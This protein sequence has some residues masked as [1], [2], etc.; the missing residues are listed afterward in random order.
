MRNFTIIIVFLLAAY[1]SNAQVNKSNLRESV[2]DSLS[3]SL[4]IQGKHQQL[5]SLVHEAL[6]YD[7]D[8]YY[9]R[10]R[11]GVSY[12][13]KKQYLLALAH[14]YKALEF[15]PA[16]FTTKEYIFYC[17]LYLG[18]IEKAKEIVQKMPITYQSYYLSFVKYSNNINIESGY[19]NTNFSSNQDTSKFLA[20]GV[21]AE[22]DRTKSLQYYQLGGDFNLTKKVK[23]Y[24][25]VSLVNNLKSQHIYS[26][27][28]YYYYDYNNSIF[29]KQIKVKDTSLEY[30]LYQYQTYLGATINLPN[31]FTLLAGFQDMY[32]KQ[33]K[34]SAISDSSKSTLLDTLVYNYRYSLQGITQNNFAT[35]LTLMKSYKNW[36][37]QMSVG[38]ANI[39]K[40]S[41]FQAGGQFI[42]FPLGNYN[43]SLTAGYY[44]SKDTL[45]R[46]I[47]LFK[48]AGKIT[49]RLWFESYHY[50]GNLKN[51][52]ESNSYV[53]YNVSDAIKS[54]S[55]VSLTYYYS[56]RLSLGVRYDLMV[57]EANYDSYVKLNN[58][59]SK[60]VQ[61]DKYNMNSFIINL[62][63][64]Y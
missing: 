18:N 11:A 14:F 34:L 15:Y 16:D 54:K 60:I 51:F 17:H 56:Q 1:N 24:A 13:N 53:I 7:I 31:Q 36:Q 47:G 43:L 61:T 6:K 12:F 44:F 57:R 26:K 2:V 52:Q 48:I 62:I 59:T 10:L 30:N 46:N 8:F 37:G 55:G 49:E 64:K 38:F 45:T 42:Y 19:Q 63:W 50:Q 3:Y 25:G 5:V 32:Y 41:I 22:S 21:F 27:D 35:S 39:V 29:N 23:L 33:S 40:T 20:D 9:L 58:T 28:N 4:A